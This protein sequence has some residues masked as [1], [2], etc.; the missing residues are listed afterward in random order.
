MKKTIKYI[1]GIVIGCLIFTSCENPYDNQ[2][3][4]LPGN[5]PQVTLQDTTG[6]A[7]VLKAGLSPL[8]ITKASLTSPLTLVTCTAVL[9]RVDTAT[10]AAYRMDFSNVSTFANYKTIALRKN[11]RAA[12]FQGS[13]CQV[14]SVHKT[15]KPSLMYK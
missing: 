4:A 14:R 10:R 9:N 5:Y 11:S 6:F 13:R 7:A 3:V 8:T 2:K 12:R 15:S 1:F